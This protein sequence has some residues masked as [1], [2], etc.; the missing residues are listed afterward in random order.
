VSRPAVATDASGARRILFTA[1]HLT[2]WAPGCE[3]LDFRDPRLRAELWVK[4]PD[5]IVR[6]VLFRLRRGPRDVSV[7]T[8][9]FEAELIVAARAAI[10]GEAAPPLA[11]VSFGPD[12]ADFHRALSSLQAASWRP[13]GLP[14]SSDLARD[15]DNRSAAA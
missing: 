12:L 3:G 5:Q 11:F 2:P 15:G 10:D 14:F 8:G 7:E 4:T 1:V 13:Q 6:A 9:P